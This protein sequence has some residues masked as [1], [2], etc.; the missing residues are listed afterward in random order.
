MEQLALLSAQYFWANHS[1]DNIVPLI[2][3]VQINATK[4]LS[5][6]IVEGT[7]PII[8]VSIC[9]FVHICPAS[10]FWFLSVPWGLINERNIAQQ[11]I[12]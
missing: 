3:Y 10:I 4:Q 2:C 1:R 12:V 9:L 6:Y 7:C 5:C 11:Q 8:F